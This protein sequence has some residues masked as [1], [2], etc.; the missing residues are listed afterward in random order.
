[1]SAANPRTVAIVGSAFIAL[2][3]GL[4]R[5]AFG[6]FLPTIRADIGFS[7]E[8][9]GII[10]A[11]PFASFVPAAM[12]APVVAGRLGPRAAAA[13][14][15]GLAALGL[16]LVSQAA[17]PV[18]LG[19]GVLIC[20]V[21]TGLSLPLMADAVDLAVP[22]NR[23]GRVN[24]TINAATSPGIAVAVPA[25]LFWAWAWREAHGLFAGLAV[26]CVLA[27]AATMPGRAH[28]SPEAGQR[29]AAALSRGQKLGL[30]QVGL[31]AGAVGFVSA[32]YWV[33]APDFVV[34][35]GGMSESHSAWLW[36]AV[37]VAGVAGSFAGDLIDRHGTA[38]SHAFALSVLAASLALLAT[39]PQSLALAAVSAGAFGAAYMTLTGVYLV[40]GTRVA[41]DRPAFGPMVPAVTAALGQT[42]G[43]A[44]AGRLIGQLGYETA[45]GLYASLGL[46]VA[47]LSPWLAAIVRPAWT[48][49]AEPE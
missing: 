25:V 22:A 46:V 44:V 11:L 40:E 20:G 18:T 35:A 4:A 19:L 49:T 14:T 12:I 2:T 41:A 8:T 24:A 43:S 16:A 15:A 42:V 33:F 5:F 28:R 17:D 3:Y 29:R 30:L 47:L 34:N 9:A 32:I 48:P 6:L 10:G 45:F 37:G 26:L 27:L 31:L 13:G 39:N 23:R 1:M 36:L 38:I 7:A 21:S